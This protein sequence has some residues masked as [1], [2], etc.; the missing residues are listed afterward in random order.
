MASM[1]RRRNLVAE[2]ADERLDRLIAQEARA[3]DRELRRLQLGDGAGRGEGA[4]RLAEGELVPP[5]PQGQPM[6]LGPE[7]AALAPLFDEALAENQLRDPGDRGGAAGRER[8]ELPPGLHGRDADG[9]G[10]GDGASQHVL[11][12]EVQGSGLPGQGLD[13]QG[14]GEVASQHVLGAEVHGPGLPG[15]GPDGQGRG[16]VASQQA[17]GAEVQGSGVPGHGLVGQGDGRGLRGGQAQGDVP[18]YGSYGPMRGRDQLAGGG[19]RQVGNGT[20]SQDVNLLG[21]RYAAPANGLALEQQVEMVENEMQA[22]LLAA[23]TP[24]R[25]DSSVNPFWSAEAKRRALIEAY[26]PAPGSVSR[27]STLPAFEVPQKD[28]DVEQLR[29]RFLKEAEDRFQEEVVRMKEGGSYHSVS[30]DSDPLGFGQTPGVRAL[31]DQV[32]AAPSLLGGLLPQ[33]PL[34]PGGLQLPQAPLQHGGPQLPAAG[35][36]PQGDLHGPERGAAVAGGLQVQA[37]FPAQGTQ[38]CQGGHHMAE[39]PGGAQQSVLTGGGNLVTS[40]PGFSHQAM[41]GTYQVVPEAPRS[42][43]LPQL[44]VIGGETAALQFGDWMTLV[45]PT[46]HDLAPSAREWWL[47]VMSE[48]EKLYQLWLLA[49][50]LQRLRIKPEMK[51]Y[52]VHLQRIE[53]KAITMLLQVLPESIKKDVVASRLLSTVNIMY[54]LHTLF[55]PGGGGERTNLLHQITSPKTTGAVSDLLASIRQ[56]RRWVSRAEELAVSLPDATV[57]VGVMAKYCDSLSK[58]GGSQLAFRLASARQELQIDYR[59]TYPAIKELS[60]F[61]QAECEELHLLN[62]IKGGGSTTASTAA[63][64]KTLATVGMEVKDE[65]PEKFSRPSCKFWKTEEGCKKGSNCTF[66]HDTTEMKGRCFACGSSGHMKKDCP[67]MQKKGLAPI[68]AEKKVAKVKNGSKPKLEQDEKSEK[69]KADLQK[70]E[71][72]KSSEEPATSA[73]STTE[74][75]ETEDQVQTLLRKATGILKGL[76]TLKTSQMKTMRLKQ[77][78]HVAPG[79]DAWA[80]IDGGA[81]HALRTAKPHE[82]AD[83]EKVQVE[84]ASG[85]VWLMRHPSH[86]TLLSAEE[87]EPIL[88]VHMLLERGYKLDWQRHHCIFRHPVKEDLSCALRGGC[89]VMDRDKA[90]ALLEVFE[91]EQRNGSPLDEKE[92]DWW[93]QRFPKVPAEVWKHMEGQGQE[94]DGERCPWNRRKRRALLA[95]KG[96]VLHLYAGEPEVWTKEYWLGYDFLAVDVNMGTQFSMHNP[97]TWA[98]LWKLASL[99]K[100]RVVIGGPPCRTTSRLR[101]RAPPGPRPIRSRGDERFVRCGATEAEK[102]LAHGDTAL[103]LKQLGLWL[104]ASETNPYE[105]PVGFGMENPEDPANY[106]SEKEVMENGYPSFWDFEEVK[107]FLGL[108]GLQLI[109]F[110]QSRMGHPRKKPTSFLTNLPGMTDLDGMRGGGSSVPPPEGLEQRMEQSRSWAKWA[111]GLV[112]ALKASIKIYLKNLPEKPALQAARLD[113]EGWKE[114]IR[115][116]HMPYRRDCRRCMELMG[117]DAPHRRSHADHS[118]YVLSIDIIGPYPVGKDIGLEKEG[119]YILVGTVPIPRL[120]HYD[121]QLPGDAEEAPAALPGAA[122]AEDALPEVAEAEDAEAPLPAPEEDQDGHQAAE[123]D[124]QPEEEDRERLDVEKAKEINQAWMDHIKDLNE[125]VGLQN[126]TMGEIIESRHVEKILAGLNRLLAR[127]RV[128]GVKVNRLHSDRESAFNSRRFIMWCKEKGLYQTMTGGDEGPSNGR[129]EGEVNQVKRRLRLMMKESKLEKDY[130]PCAAR[131]VLEQRCREQ[132]KKMGVPVKPMLKLGAKVVVKVKRWHKKDGPLSSPFVTMKVMAPSPW[133]TSGWVLMDRK[134]IQHARAAVLPAAEGERAVV[135]LQAVEPKRVHG[136]SANPLNYADRL[137]VPPPLQHEELPL[138]LQGELH[139]PRD[140]PQDHGPHLP[141]EAPMI[142]DGDAAPALRELQ[143]GGESLQV[144]RKSRTF[145]SAT[146]EPTATATCGASTCWV[147][148]GPYGVETYATTTEEPRSTAT[149]VACDGCGLTQQHSGWCPM[150]EEPLRRPMVRVAALTCCGST[151]CDG[152]DWTVE[153]EPLMHRLR[154]EHWKW[155]CLWDE[156]MAKVAVGGEEGQLHGEMLQYLESMGWDLEEELTDRE[157]SRQLDKD[158]G[159]AKIATLDGGALEETDTAHAVL[160]TYTVPLAEVRRDLPL[161][162]EALKK[163]LHSLVERTGTIRRVN[164]EDLP[165]EIGF[166]KMQIAPAKIVPTIKAPHGVRKA[167]IVVCGNLVEDVNPDKKAVE[168]KEKDTLVNPLYAGGLDGTALRCVLRLAAAKQWC[169]ASTD[170]KTAFLLAPRQEAQHS[171]LVVRP[172]TLLREAGLATEKERWIVQNAWYGLD[173]SPRNWADYR[174]AEVRKFS[175]EDGDKVFWLLQ[176]PEKN[177]WRILSRPRDGMD[178]NMAKVVD[179]NEIQTEGYVVVYVDDLLVVG[180]DDV[181]RACLG[182]IRS[183]WEC[184]EPT[185]VGDKEWTRFCGLE[186]MWR[187]EELLVSQQAYAKELGQRH[188]PMTP[189][190]T[191]FPKMEADTEETETEI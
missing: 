31:G 78:A 167:R 55:Q 191:P 136:K 49:S 159:N 20:G 105:E 13:G 150:C 11:G 24:E 162:K 114:H 123:D 70:E 16:D 177:L 8:P 99:G 100:I 146:E 149:W 147:Q 187:G 133:M 5:L 74:E 155:K 10:A 18:G 152:D 42:S 83:A 25:V 108:H 113:V 110:D 47:L 95:S 64:V 185:W 137:M 153:E 130:W 140:L 175:W 161:W 148:E 23:V 59:P 176:C 138:A 144:D 80:L 81:T 53:Q 107:Q 115:G 124:L 131:W 92:L 86:R 139:L 151:A 44:P 71:N 62:G 76:R 179:D 134:R 118:A 160:Q 106:L 68:P 88:P 7:A 96:I 29:L 32:N 40:P 132:L 188:G 58:L 184:S 66:G 180:S 173:S 77:I 50:P 79:R 30:T 127:Y 45:G 9:R 6:A 186:L 48:V 33:V 183:Q 34:P 21:N 90:L 52:P 129:I 26:A 4:E 120:P 117:V 36:I 35:T 112:R 189:R 169:A 165:K 19:L 43:D 27:P 73:T 181:V 190:S 122:E 15:Q 104:K 63:A 39:T 2:T 158:L 166:E 119:K 94:I 41:G 170:V 91:M 121:D 172:P 87:I 109:H 116:G 75:P 85:S 142:E 1:R 56:W 171:L 156:E 103:V 126:L 111:P 178:V 28:Q 69:P 60:E 125:P 61:V 145:L 37:G 82:I 141:A 102:E 65:K 157:N 89:P 12:A 128:M 67:P 97:Q 46:M 14:R 143:A 93:R 22:R 51:A 84:L 163:E 168:S 17:L 38:G 135:E 174:D 3:G 101:H 164:V 182:R 98:F 154:E 54:R 72:V 57:L